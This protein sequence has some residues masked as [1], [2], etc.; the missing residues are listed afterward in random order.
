MGDRNEVS[1]QI[2]EDVA[3]KLKFALVHLKPMKYSNQE[4][5]ELN[6]MLS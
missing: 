3:Y 2:G 4:L 1:V 6:V 5:D